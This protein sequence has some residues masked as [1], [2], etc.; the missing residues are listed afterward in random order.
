MRPLTGIHELL[1]H[2]LLEI[3]KRCQTLRQDIAYF[4]NIVSILPA[5]MVKVRLY[6]MACQIMIQAQNL[7]EQHH[8]NGCVFIVMDNMAF[9]TYWAEEE[10]S[11]EDKEDFK[12]RGYHIV[13]PE[14][15]AEV[16]EVL[17]E[18]VDF[19]QLA[20]AVG[21]INRYEPFLLLNDKKLL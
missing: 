21:W 15:I 4:A 14:T 10:Y 2:D 5:E 1:Q 13:S 11:A 19:G 8:G 6:S 12:R 16:A 20:E 18:K 7:S 9:V 3:S 17:S